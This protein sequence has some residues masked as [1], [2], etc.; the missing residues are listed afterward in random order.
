[1]GVSLVFFRLDIEPFRIDLVSM[2][3]IVYT[4][5]NFVLYFKEK[6]YDVES[7]FLLGFLS[8]VDRKVGIS[9]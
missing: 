5:D 2:D 9:L 3:S 6:R 1:M 7:V 8:L 4:Y